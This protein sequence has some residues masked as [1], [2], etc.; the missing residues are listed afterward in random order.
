MRR[1]YL[2]IVVIILVG[3]SL[4][5]SAFLV[6]N[7]W[8]YKKANIS[9]ENNANHCYESLAKELQIDLTAVESL[10]AL[11]TGVPDVTRSQFGEFARYLLSMHL[12]ASGH[13]GPRMDTQNTL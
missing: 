11:Y 8:E 7:N 4:S 13:P 9:F 12:D 1:N 5:V 10:R 6:L 3:A 2:L